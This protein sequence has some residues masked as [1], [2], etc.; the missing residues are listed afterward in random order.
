MRGSVAVARLGVGAN[1]PSPLRAAQARVNAELQ[2]DER[3]HAAFPVHGP[4]AYDKGTAIQAK[5]TAGLIRDWV[6]RA[7]SD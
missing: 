4:G 2:T 7:L 3:S 1:N 6:A 5:E